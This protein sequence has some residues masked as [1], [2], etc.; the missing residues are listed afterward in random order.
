MK[1]TDGDA[2]YL[3]KIEDLTPYLDEPWKSRIKNH[4]N[5]LPSTTGDRTVYG[6]VRRELTNYHSYEGS[7]DEVPLIM[8]ELGFDNIN[9]LS[10][11]QLMLARIRGDDERMTILS[12]ALTD[13]MLDQIADPDE[14]IYFMIPAPYAAPE[15]AVDLIDRV[16]DERAVIGVCLITAGPEPPLGNRKYDPIYAKAEAMGLPV[17]FHSGG[18]GLDAFFIRGYE[19]FIET[20]TLGF[21]ESNMSQLV[22]IVVQGLLMPDVLSR[23]GLGESSSE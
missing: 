16:G 20:H 3:E 12:N 17:V 9:L 15:E 7:P 1:V 18:S 21:L 14:G 10:H 4:R 2:H 19:K 5:L 13:Y 23:V 11:T 22:S 8:D 6:R